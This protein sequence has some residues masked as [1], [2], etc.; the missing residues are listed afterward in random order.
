[1][2]IVQL[3]LQLEIALTQFTRL[4]TLNLVDLQRLSLALHTRLSGWQ[5]AIAVSLTD[6]GRSLMRLGL[7]KVALGHAHVHRHLVGRRLPSSNIIASRPV[8][9]A[10]LIPF[11]LT[12]NDLIA[13]LVHLRC[14]ATILTDLFAADDLAVAH[15]GQRRRLVWLYLSCSLIELSIA[16]ARRGPSYTLRLL[17]LRQTCHA[18]VNVRYNQL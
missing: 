15:G 17:S 1:M 5:A 12:V 9:L 7:L 14:E 13:V 4:V 11:E 6:F 16:V 8:E 10:L 3:L 2:R 18:V